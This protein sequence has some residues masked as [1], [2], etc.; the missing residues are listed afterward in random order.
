MKKNLGAEEYRSRSAR[1]LSDSWL[2]A[3][4]RG[5]S[6]PRSRKP[7]EYWNSVLMP[8]ITRVLLISFA[9]NDDFLERFSE[10]DQQIIEF[11]LGNTGADRELLCQSAGYD[12]DQLQDG[13]AEAEDA[14]RAFP[15]CCLASRITE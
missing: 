6:Y 7:P 12:G 8:H 3:V 13:G 1:F 10:K 14:G 11:A 5:R 15:R 2:K 9:D 4:A